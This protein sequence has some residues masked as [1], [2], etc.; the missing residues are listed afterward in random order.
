MNELDSIDAVWALNHA[1]RWPDE[2]G[3]TERAVAEAM[4]AEREKRCVK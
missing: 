2:N 1:I 4:L 3:R